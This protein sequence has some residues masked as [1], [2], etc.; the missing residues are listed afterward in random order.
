M[1]QLLHMMF[2][3]NNQRLLVIV[4]AALWSWTTAA[5]GNDSIP[6][7]YRSHLYVPACIN[8]EYQAHVIFDTGASNLF[9]IDS[10][11]LSASAWNPQDIGWGKTGGAAG[12]TRVLVILDSTAVSIGSLSSTYQIVPIFK[13]R[14]VIDCHVD[15]IW[16]IKDI[17]QHPS[18]INYE[19]GFL[20][21]YTDG[22]PPIEGYEKLPIRFQNHRI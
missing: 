5:W 17:E 16:G 19:H 15:G 6:F 1:N 22:N 3:R 18:E 8:N 4:L 21:Y 11:Y 12:S 20:K 14:D 9:G 7:L 13:L 2:L 10:V